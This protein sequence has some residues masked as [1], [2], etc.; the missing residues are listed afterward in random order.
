MLVHILVRPQFV[1]AESPGS[2]NGL[3]KFGLWLEVEDALPYDIKP[4]QIF[5]IGCRD[6]Q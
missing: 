6:R 5:V 4:F 2:D 1:R 3:V